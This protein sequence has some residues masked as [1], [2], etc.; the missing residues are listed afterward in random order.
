MRSKKALFNIATKI[1]LQVITILYGFLLPNILIGKYGSEVNGLIS[2]ITQLLAYISL[3]ESG[4]G[5]VLKATLYKPLAN[6]NKKEIVNILSASEK[7]FRIIS[8][9]FII[10]II[11]LSIAY[12]LLFGKTFSFIYTFSLVIIISIST[13]FQYYFGMTYRLFLQ[14]DQKSYIISIVSIIT[15]TIN[16]I[17]LFVLSIY[18]LPVHFLM[19]T[20]SLASIIRPLFQNWYVKK[21]YNISLDSVDEKYSIKNK[22]DGLAQHIAAVVHDNTDITLVT[23]FCG[24]VEVSVYSIYHLVTF[25]I[26]NFVFSLADGIDSSFG[27]MIANGEKSNLKEK[28]R[29]YETLY[30]SICT[31]I[32]S[33]TLILILPFVSLYTKGV[34]DANYI[35]PLFAILIVVSEIVFALRMPYSTIT[36]AAGHFKETRVGAWIESVT[37]III[38][39]ILIFKYGLVGAAIGTTVAMLIRTVEFVYHTNKYIIFDKFYKSI[40]KL[41]VCGIEVVFIVVICNNL[42]YMRYDNFVNFIFN[43][44]KILSISTG[45]TAMINIFLYKKDFKKIIDV[46]KA[47]IKKNI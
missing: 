28:F 29:M 38:S 43:S 7:F 23:I 46:S 2:S 37:N 5:P 8:Y 24:L 3:L 44:I 42:S 20:L 13:L 30:I 35:R 18:N 6:K 39:I 12:P 1:I 11:I 33:C 25:G 10:Y 41:I 45:I 15:Y 27:S 9:I 47:L 19:F 21:K 40:F 36:K 31:V 14:A 4:F 17:L 26:R 16:V 22:W 34:S 32:Y